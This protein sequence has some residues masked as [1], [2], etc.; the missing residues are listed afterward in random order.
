MPIYEYLC[1]TCGNTIEVLQGLSDPA[2]EECPR[3]DGGT[4]KRILSVHNIGATATGFEGAACELS[5]DP[6][7]MTCGK[8]G[9]GCG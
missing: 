7:C 6:T 2:P 4:L 8:A 5:D 1:D 9:T 3:G